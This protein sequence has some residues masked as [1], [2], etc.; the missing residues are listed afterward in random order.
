MINY[1]LSK[2]NILINYVGFTI[3]WF[4]CVYSGA[5]GDPIIALIPTFIFLFL[6]FLI[7][8][9]HFKEEIQ[10]IVIS[11]IFGLIQ[12]Y[13]RFCA[14]SSTTLDSLYVGRFYSSDKSCYEI[15]DW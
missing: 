7:V 13:I 10:L 14:K 1:I 15:F 3:V 12:W 4:S 2:I 9:D 11:I 6:H 8:T 5:Q